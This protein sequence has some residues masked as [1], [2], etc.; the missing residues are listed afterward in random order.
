MPAFLVDNLRFPF[1]IIDFFQSLIFL[2][3]SH[4]F[5]K[6]LQREQDSFVNKLEISVIKYACIRHVP[7]L[8]AHAEKERKKK[9]SS[10]ERKVRNCLGEVR[11][12][13]TAKGSEGGA[14]KW[15]KTL[16][17]LPSI[18]LSLHEVGQ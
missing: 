6:P 14:K 2:A 11:S 18:S 16:P 13:V 1:P 4:S 12:R 8:L 9:V 15:G 3:E 10:G 17:F 7:I 5:L